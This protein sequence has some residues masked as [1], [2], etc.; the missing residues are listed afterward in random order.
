MSRNR[1]ASSFL[2]LIKRPLNLQNVSNPKLSSKLSELAKAFEDE[3]EVSFELIT[4]SKLTEA[5]TAD[6]EVFQRKLAE[7]S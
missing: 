4:T 3:Y 1:F 7:M 6:L 2:W 5:A